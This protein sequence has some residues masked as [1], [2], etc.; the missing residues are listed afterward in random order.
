MRTVVFDIETANWFGETES[1]DPSK[2]TIALVGVHDSLSGEYACYLEQELPQLW[3]ILE[4]TDMLVGYN[5]DHFDIPLLNKYYPGD[6]SRI[7]SLDLMK[8]IYE[9]AGRRI[10]LDDVASAT[11]GERKSADGAQSLRWWRADEVDKV[12]HYCLKDVEITK[13][14]FE[15]ALAHGSVKYKEL[16]KAREIKLDTS[17]WLAGESGALTRTLGF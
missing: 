2:L 5:S 15:H 7:R 8:E 4:Q 16:G 3:K 17:K 13:K 12:R 11:L 14:L 9:V 1:Y 10:K 6:L